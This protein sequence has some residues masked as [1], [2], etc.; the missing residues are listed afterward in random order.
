MRCHCPLVGVCL[1][2]QTLRRLVNRAAGGEVQDDDYEVH[3]GSVSECVSR[4]RFSE[5]LQ[6]ELE[7][8]YAPTIGRFRQA[9]STEAVLSLWIEAVNSG[10]V[11]GAL[12][13]ALTHPRCDPALQ[14]MLCR[15]MHMLQHQ[16]DACIRADIG[17]LNALAE[18]NVLLASQLEE[19][20]RRTARLLGERDEELR[21]QEAQCARLRTELIGKEAQASAMG[22]E[23]AALKA[24][25]PN[26]ESRARLQE[27]IDR[28]MARAR[29]A[30]A[31]LALLQQAPEP[32]HPAAPPPEPAS[33][34]SSCTPVALDLHDRSVLCVG[35]RS[36]SVATYRDLIE[37]VGGRF[38]HHDGGR[39]DNSR[40]LE[41]TLAAADL[42]I[43]QTGCISHQAY[44]RVKDHCK[45]HGKRCVFVDNPS[46]SSLARSMNALPDSVADEQ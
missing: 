10:D 30:D 21:R 19:G 26:L 42:V 18:Q 43:C 20:Q 38:A 25:I 22:A 15:D 37:G 28:L 13:A 8:R 9:K 17:R 39:E 23:L 35:G 11:A 41:T 5:A 24:S 32:A 46:I 29:E 1:P 3:V 31:Q 33:P 27:K 4:N 6:D 34:P 14:E 7:R 2:L 16:A 12:W 40:Q 36:G 44:W 45:R